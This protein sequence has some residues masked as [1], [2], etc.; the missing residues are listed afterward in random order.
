M[1]RCMT[2]ECSH[3]SE[4]LAGIAGCA[5]AD[6]GM[7]GNDVGLGARANSCTPPVAF[8]GMGASLPPPCVKCL[9]VLVLQGCDTFTIS[10][11][12]AMKLFK[13]TQTI[14]AV[15]EF[16]AAA[17]RNGAYEYE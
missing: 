3:L 8:P 10:P 17:R 13:V 12:V 14:D 5:R 1:W 7:L 15:A 9:V 16:E 6:V 4:A 2:R 11:A